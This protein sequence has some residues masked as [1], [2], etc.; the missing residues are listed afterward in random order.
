MFQV[1]TPALKKWNLLRTG[2]FVEWGYRFP[3]KLFRKARNVGE[4]PQNPRY[5]EQVWS[6]RHLHV[7]ILLYSHAKWPLI[8]HLPVP[9]SGSTNG[10]A[11]IGIGSPLRSGWLTN[12]P[13]RELYRWSSG[14]TA[15]A[16]S[17]SIV[18]T[19]VVAT[20]ISPPESDKTCVLSR[21][22]PLLYD[23][24]PKYWTCRLCCSSVRNSMGVFVYWYGPV[25]KALVY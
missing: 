21:T 1:P 25:P 12:R 7:N 3:R 9:N 24:F 5:H 2:Y 17:P 20:T 11:M 10:S 15:T 8:L 13:I 19:R 18:S 23:V 16:T 22:S 4:Q 14:C 6:S